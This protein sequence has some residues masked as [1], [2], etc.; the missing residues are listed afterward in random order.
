LNVNAVPDYVTADAPASGRHDHVT[1]SLGVKNL[2]NSL[3]F[4]AAGGD[5]RRLGG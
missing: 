1:V 5:S 3:H 2:T 4:V